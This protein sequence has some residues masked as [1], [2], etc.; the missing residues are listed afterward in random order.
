MNPNDWK[1]DSWCRYLPHL[2]RHLAAPDIETALPRSFA[3]LSF[4]DSCAWWETLRYLCRSLLGWRCLPAGL[5]WWYAQGKPDLG[6]A[7][8]RLVLERW[9]TRNELDYFAAREWE[10]L[11][12]TGME[13]EDPLWTT[14]DFEPQPGWWRELRARHCLLEHSPYGGGWNPMHLGHSDVVGETCVN[15]PSTG[16]HDVKTRRA[17]LVAACF[18][19]WRHDLRSF[20]AT[21]P[22][23][24]DHSWHVNV[25]DG[26]VGHLGTFRQSRVTGR[27]FQGAHS[28]HMA[29]NPGRVPS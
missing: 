16:S 25:F 12:R 5:A 7:C 29:G 19:S 15:S 26:E 9:N 3:S 27:W 8:L 6:D 11:G 22:A 4:E 1:Q 2:H 24:G 10:T 21:L 20:G 17:T 13:N 18:G 14:S 23:I 28:L